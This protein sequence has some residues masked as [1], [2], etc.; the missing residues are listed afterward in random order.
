MTDSPDKLPNNTP[1]Y[2]SN[3][4]IRF[5]FSSLMDGLR[6]LP[7]NFSR[8]WPTMLIMLIF[9]L[10]PVVYK[11]YSADTAFLNPLYFLTGGS[12]GTFEPGIAAFIGGT[13]AKSI[14]LAAYIS[15][16]L[17]LVHKKAPLS[18]KFISG[19]FKKYTSIFS[20]GL[21]GF[22]AALSGFGAALIIHAFIS[23]DGSL[24]KS[25]ASLI[26]MVY[27]MKSAAFRTT[28][29]KGI[30]ESI[31]P[32]KESIGTPLCI[33]MATGFSVSF[34]ITGFITSVSYFY[35]A[36][37]MTFIPGILFISATGRENNTVI[38]VYDP[39]FTTAILVAFPISLRL[40][41]SNFI[42]PLSDLNLVLPAISAVIALIIGGILAG[43]SNAE[44]LSDSVN[45]K[46]RDFKMD[47]FPIEG[48]KIKSDQTIMLS[49][50]LYERIL[51]DDGTVSDKSR[52]EL[53]SRISITASE[54][55]IIFSEPVMSDGIKSISFHIEPAFHNDMKGKDISIIFTSNGLQK[56]VLKELIFH[57]AGEPE[58]SL[59]S[60]TLYIR[61]ESGNTS[62]FQFEFINFLEK[63]TKIEV[64]TIDPTAPF[65][66]RAGRNKYGLP[67]I[68]VRITSVKKYFEEF[69]EP[70]S[71]QIHAANK[72]ESALFDFSIVLCHEGIL[73]DFL[74]KSKE[75][76]GFKNEI[77]G[78]GMTE[79]V[80]YVRSGIWDY[81]RKALVLQAPDEIEMSF[82]D[83][84]GIFEL[85]GITLDVN[86]DRTTPN[87][88]AYTIK[89]DKCFASASPVDGKMIIRGSSN[90]HVFENE[91]RI[92][93]IPDSLH[94]GKNIDEEFSECL[95]IIDTYMPGHYK[96]DKLKEF[97]RF[98][99]ILGL[100]DLRLFH[101]NCWQTAQ[102]AVLE[103]Q[104]DYTLESTW[105]NR[106]IVTQPAI[107]YIADSTFDT[108]S[109]SIGTPLSVFLEAQ[110]KYRLLELI[111]IYADKP[112][113]S[114]WKLTL[115]YLNELL[116]GSTDSIKRPI[117]IPDSDNPE[118]LSVWLA[119]FAI[120]RT[121]Y[122]WNFD[123]DED[124]LSIGIS[125]SIR[126]GISDLIDV[127][128]KFHL[129]DFIKAMEHDSLSAT[130][131]PYIAEELSAGTT[132]ALLRFINNIAPINEKM[133]GDD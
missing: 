20:N 124:G 83:N 127:K 3:N 102:S 54:K 26:C 60:D 45:E 31:F 120:Y 29:L 62:E 76:R 114:L 123:K 57:V 96:S 21:S 1:I 4:L 99:K 92:K 28:F 7:Q 95:N 91:I 41:M 93:L 15:I 13:L 80:F 40:N 82:H 61:A 66:I 65:T 128:A 33:G 75:I 24:I 121:S 71:C 103:E 78:H 70:F 111:A 8:S 52:P 50:A 38:S 59:S 104:L 5:M 32:R 12:N 36:G 133:P 88:V 122:H 100:Q 14:I 113:Q 110:M 63:I 16:I 17:K 132:E 72:N 125:E 30:T 10:F 56:N 85:I 43:A 77:H 87:A 109:S 19:F 131:S 89:A 67:V 74:G 105:F 25:S 118:Q 48:K 73:P 98:E 49:V 47:I 69:H 22:G 39:F 84:R 97:T 18:L 11:H 115:E 34:L 90:G 107:V 37:L 79:T 44:A 6:R 53:T 112:E 101:I 42:A 126:L 58:I 119:G 68:I 130:V 2:L 46:L 129:N 94:F 64:N 86:T 9:W 51:E 27:A 35:L 81:D 106:P 108:A 23:T 116:S 55:S 117:E